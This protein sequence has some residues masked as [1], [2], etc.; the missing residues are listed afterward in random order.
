M[1]KMITSVFLLVS[2]FSF[3]KEILNLF[4]SFWR[5]NKNLVCWFSKR[6]SD[7]Q[8]FKIWICRNLPKFFSKRRCSSFRKICLQRFRQK[9]RRLDWIHVSFEHF[10]PF[11]IFLVNFYK[12]SRSHH[13]ATS[14]KNLNVRQLELQKTYFLFSRGVQIVRF[15]Q[16]RRHNKRRNARNRA[17][18]IFNARRRRPFRAKF[19]F[20]WIESR[21]HLFQNGRCKKDFFI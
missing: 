5:R 18:D 17:G 11:T 7:R 15:G 16:Q 20:A 6:L 4:F 9:W 1:K 19:S 21:T 12:H 3:E 10:L 8:A 13:V 2:F 14:T